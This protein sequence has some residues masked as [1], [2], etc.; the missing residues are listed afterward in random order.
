[1]AIAETWL[2]KGEDDGCSA[3]S[4]LMARFEPKALLRT[5]QAATGTISPGMVALLARGLAERSDDAS[6]ELLADFLLTHPERVASSFSLAIQR[7]EDKADATRYRRLDH[8]HVEAIWRA[9]FSEVLW[10]SALS[11][12]CTLRPDLKV[13][14]EKMADSYDGIEAI[15]MRYCAGTENET[16]LAALEQLLESD[17]VTLKDEP[18]EFFR[19]SH[20]DW[21]GHEE[22]I[23]R[24]LAR[25]LPRLRQ[26]LLK[27][28]VDVSALARGSVGL[29]T[30]QPAIE[31]VE[32][33]PASHDEWWTLHRLGMI[34]AH[35]GDAEVRAFCLDKL[36]HGSERLKM[37][38]KQSYLGV[39]ENLTSDALDDDMIA[40]LLADL[41]VPH[42]IS[43]YWY[44]PLGWIAT[45]R[46]V[47]ERLLPL[48]QNASP[49]FRENLV[50]VLKAAGDRYGKRYLLPK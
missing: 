1:M 29:A 31:L 13:H 11:R 4:D 2:A 16:L 21:R 47:H 50:R 5:A 37:W 17:D 7:N 23:V 10:D 39:V 26:A 20:L 43:E 32:V 35:L 48:A 34:V 30:M 22:L 28:L 9:R 33:G 45:D 25:D 3:I 6:F 38:V 36:V 42:R 27:D 15:A 40:A 19:L 24:S 46:F 14:V 49:A 44:N 8:R 12:V 41:N 18:F